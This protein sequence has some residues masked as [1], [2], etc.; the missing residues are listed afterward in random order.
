MIILHLWLTGNSGRY[1]A[2]KTEVE[3]DHFPFLR[4]GQL[5]QLSLTLPLRMF[6]PKK[7]TSFQVRSVLS[8]AHHST[9][10]LDKEF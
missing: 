3:R 1:Q 9:E 6:R 7:Y 8:R 4:V 10:M 2:I 5:Y